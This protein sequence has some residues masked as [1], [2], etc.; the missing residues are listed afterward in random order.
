[1]SIGNLLRPNGYALYSGSLSASQ[2][3]SANQ[4]MCQY[5]LLHGIIFNATNNS[6]LDYYEEYIQDAQISG[7]FNFSIQDGL[8]ITRIGK[9]IS[10]KI[11]S[12]L[13]L[14]KHKTQLIIGEIPEKF[15]PDE[16]IAYR[17]LIVNN[18]DY[19]DGLLVV[20]EDG[21][22][23]ISP[24]FSNRDYFIINEY[25][26]LPYDIELQWQVQ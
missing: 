26:G 21:Y 17:I 25:A 8:I 24:I 16:E 20:N 3:V 6:K 5:I 4:I 11:R 14:A 2:C 15:T 22:I 19:S 12:F 1:M 18:D 9:S 13:E 7:I 10:C 23:E